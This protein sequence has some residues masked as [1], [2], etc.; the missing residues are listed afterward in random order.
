MAANPQPGVGEIVRPD[1]LVCFAVREEAKYFLNSKPRMA[2]SVITGMGQMNSSAA[3]E[4]RLGEIST[5]SLVLTCG[6]AGGLNPAFKND[7]IIFSA[8]EDQPKLREALEK[9]GAT[10][11]NFYCATRVAISSQE[12]L[13]LWH[14]TG[15]DAVEME[16]D[17]IRDICRDRGIPSA[18]VRSISD[19]AMEDLPLDFNTLMT[20][21]QNINYRKLAWALVRAPMKV[22]ELLAFQQKTQSAAKALGDY[23]VKLLRIYPAS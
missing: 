22:A 3:V 14:A 10:K 18:T 23:L 7:Q 13:N 4:K 2:R 8:D 19:S 20:P 1:V 16:S 9:A 5:P 6:F 12:K 21:T 11:A 17:V 15:L